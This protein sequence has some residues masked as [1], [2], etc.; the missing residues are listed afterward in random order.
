MAISRWKVTTAFVQASSGRLIQEA[1]RWL[2]LVSDAVNAAA[3]QIGTVALATQ[4]A[5]VTTTTIP[6]PVLSTGLYRVSYSLRITRAATV[7]SSAT[8]T[9]GWTSNGVACTQ[10]GAAVTG[11]TTSTQQNGVLVI[12][13]DVSTVVTYAVAYASA[14]ATSMQWALDVRL[15]A[16][17]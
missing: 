14:G 10:A 11:N 15:E 4:G 7:S 2:N 16:C 5:A 9:L 17:P 3:Q 12:A 1:S 6:A 13:A 8:L